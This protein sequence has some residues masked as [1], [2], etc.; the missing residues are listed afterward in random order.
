MARLSRWN[1]SK[2]LCFAESDAVGESK[3]LYTIVTGKEVVRNN[4]LIPSGES[5]FK[6][7]ALLLSQHKIS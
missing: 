1:E 6:V 2:N 4:Q 7:N 3:S 5:H